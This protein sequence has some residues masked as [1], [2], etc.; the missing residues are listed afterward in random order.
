M[1]AESKAD[2]HGSHYVREEEDVFRK[3]R[4]NHFQR[5][6]ELEQMKD[7]LQQA[8]MEFIA[9]IDADTHGEVTPQSERIYCIARECGK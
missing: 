2:W 7:A 1:E 8:G 4:E 9:A 3:F 5:G 6:Y